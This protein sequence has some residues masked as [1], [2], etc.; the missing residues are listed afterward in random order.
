MQAAVS[1][2][3]SIA[4]RSIHEIDSQ[5]AEILTLN[6]SIDAWKHLWLQQ[7]TGQILWA[8]SVT[9]VVEKNSVAFLNRPVLK[10]KDKAFPLQVMKTN[11]EDGML[12]FHPYWTFGTTRTAD[13]SALCP[14]RILLLKKYGRN[15]YQQDALFFLNYI[16]IIYPLNVSNRVTVHDQEALTAYAAYVIYCSASRDSTPA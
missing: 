13:L 2:E 10:V 9:C 3:K 11:R 15:K 16:S 8:F 6:T 4:Y 5:N 7:S 12:C 1:F 14:G